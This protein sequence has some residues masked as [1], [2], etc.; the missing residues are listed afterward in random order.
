VGS[1][2]S[3]PAYSP[4]VP[5]NNW[6]AVMFSGGIPSSQTGCKKCKITQIGCKKYSLNSQ[7]TQLLNGP[8]Y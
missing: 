2:G 6:F 5:N 7:I 4:N 3:N 8:K 1:V